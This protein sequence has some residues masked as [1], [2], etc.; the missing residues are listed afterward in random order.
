MTLVHLY[1]RHHTETLH[2]Q[3]CLMVLL[4]LDECR[5]YFKI[6]A[7]PIKTLLES[8]IEIDNIRSFMP[9]ADDDCLRLYRCHQILPVRTNN[10]SIPE[11]CK[12]VVIGVIITSHS[13][14]YC[15]SETCNGMFDNANHA[16]RYIDCI[17]TYAASKNIKVYAIRNSKFSSLTKNK[18]CVMHN[19]NEI[20]NDIDNM[21]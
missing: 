9:Y 20:M 12:C 19:A 15:I 3:Q 11:K 5:S 8:R 10:V 4:K 18:V 1:G 7:I 14:V 17:V 6:T 21:D 2:Q 16:I 13:D